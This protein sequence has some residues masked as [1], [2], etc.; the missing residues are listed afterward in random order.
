M[1]DFPERPPAEWDLEN[2][3]Q[4]L[5]IHVGT[6]YAC[7]ACG[8]LVMV[9]RG[10]VGVMELNCCGQPMQKVQPTEGGER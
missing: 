5:T 4:A 1:S 7:K 10:G 9:T 3:E 2:W 6:A 8:N